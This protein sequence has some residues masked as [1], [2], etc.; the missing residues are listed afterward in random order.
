[1][2]IVVN[3]LLTRYETAG[4]GRVVLLLHGWGDSLN[5]MA[6]LQKA[7]AGNYQVISV[8]L[9][10][11]GQ[12]QAPQAAWNLDNY[13]EFVA[14]FLK[15]LGVQELYAV[16][17]HSN[18]GALAIRAVSLGAL[19]P[20]KLVLLAAA[21]IRTSHGGRR[22]L[23]KIIAKAG[24]I[25]T[26]WLPERYRRAL[27]KSLYGVA[28]SDML[29]APHLQETFKITVRQDVQADAAQITL[30]TL[31]IYAEDDRAVP[32]LDGQKYNKLIK[33]STLKVLPGGHFVH[34]D[35]AEVVRQAVGEF[36]A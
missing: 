26:I 9:P 7:L 34:I 13:A 33:N 20:Q 31:L 27:R 25:A 16:V 23:L 11:F 19:A 17:G 21:G 22:L 29:V 35:N 10:G 36:L 32:L 1:M 6:G 15:K 4:N 24:N 12:T 5:G 18:G 28:G 2:Q 8:D 14:A 3:E 30:P